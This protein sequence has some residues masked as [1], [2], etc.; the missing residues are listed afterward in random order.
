MRP[1]ESQ[2]ITPNAEACARGTPALIRGGCREQRFQTV[3]PALCHAVEVLQRCAA[4]G[5]YRGIERRRDGAVVHV[6]TH[7][8][9]LGNFT[10]DLG[11]NLHQ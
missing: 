9:C 5:A 1:L 4:S 8:Q 2:S 10:N 7:A 3:E 11:V 6:A